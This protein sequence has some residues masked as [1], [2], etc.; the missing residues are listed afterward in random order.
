LDNDVFTQP[1]CVPTTAT[2]APATTVAAAPVTVPAVTVT[3]FALPTDI[4]LPRTGNDVGATPYIGMIALGLGLA[5]I[6]LARR[7]RPV[8]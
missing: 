5:A 2:Q 3:T 4:T 7:R 6:V 1:S 8:A